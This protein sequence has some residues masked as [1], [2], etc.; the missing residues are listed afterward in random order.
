MQFTDTHADRADA[1]IRLFRDTFTASEGADEGNL[2]ATLVTRIFSDVAPDDMAVFSAR[3]GG[4]LVGAIIFTR[5]T[6]PQEARTVFLLSPVAVATD[7]R[8]KG[9]GQALLTHGL[10]TLRQRGVDVV[11][12]Y[13][14]INFYAKVGFAQITEDTARPPMPLSYPEGWL[15]QSLTQPELAPLKGPSTCV[16]PFNDPALW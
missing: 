13:G 7:H 6:Y 11:V 16:G 8:G 4:T 1:I 12:T 3:D 2:I 9:I 14:D 15:G 5:L 10:D